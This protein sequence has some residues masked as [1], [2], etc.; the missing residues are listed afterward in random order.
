MMSLL[1]TFVSLCSKTWLQQLQG[2][3][4]SLVRGFEVISI[5]HSEEGMTKFIVAG[6]FG[7]L[8]IMNK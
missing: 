3:G 1:A 8:F 5:Q 2:V 7:I 4:V 6:R